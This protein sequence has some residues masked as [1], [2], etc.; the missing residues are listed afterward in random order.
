MASNNGNRS[1]IRL[2]VRALDA[3]YD[4]TF[5][6]LPTNTVRSEKLLTATSPRIPTLMIID[7]LVFPS[8]DY[9]DMI[10]DLEP[11]IARDLI[12]GDN[13]SLDPLELLHEHEE[14]SNLVARLQ[15]FES[16]TLDLESAVE[17]LAER[18]EHLERENT[19]ISAKQEKL[20]AF[21]RA[22]HCIMAP[23]MELEFLRCI[24]QFLS[25]A[26][27]KTEQGLQNTDE[28]L[29]AYIEQPAQVRLGKGGFVTTSTALSSE[30]ADQETVSVML[31]DYQHY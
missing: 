28:C 4:D 19:E 7:P 30:K 5:E 15:E 17:G 18:I 29:A 13:S 2:T 8:N 31:S 20:A 24:Q 9:D 6:E 1:P 21:T 10:D 25:D 14:Q 12:N 26:A 22:H 11:N 23:V 16:Q 3:D 27:M